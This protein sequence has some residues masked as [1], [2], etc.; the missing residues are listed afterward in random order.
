MNSDYITDK[1][2][3]RI[4]TLRKLQ[5]LGASEQF[6]IYVYK[7]EIRSILEYGV[8]VWNGAITKQ[9]SLKIENIQKIVLRL[10]LREKYTSYTD[11]CKNFKLEKLHE[12]R[13]KLCI[14][15]ARKEYAKPENGIFLKS[16]TK[17][18]RITSKKLV[19]EPRAR[20]T[21]Y[22]NSSLPYLARLL[23]THGT[24]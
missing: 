10:L 16:Q 23:N 2:R 4:C 19:V 20:T 11:A 8:P 5:K 24:K 3:L 17:S 1:A 14:K 12:R 13:E 15:F 9:D 21:R 6:I 7:K 22:Y 18:K